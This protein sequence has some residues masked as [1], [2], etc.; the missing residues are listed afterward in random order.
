MLKRLDRYA[1]LTA[2]LLIIICTAQL[3][4]IAP[5][6]R[7]VTALLDTLESRLAALE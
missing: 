2:A 1:T 7:R 3:F 4:W 6:R 5:I